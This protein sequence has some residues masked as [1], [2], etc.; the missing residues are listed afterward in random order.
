MQLPVPEYRHVARLRYAMEIPLG[1]MAD[2]ES[3]ARIDDAAAL[4]AARID[5]RALSPQEEIEFDRWLSADVRRQGAFARALAIAIHMAQV[6]S[7]KP[8][9]R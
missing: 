1:Q 6:Q 4:W 9:S 3:S 7:P 8:D 5:A 2:R